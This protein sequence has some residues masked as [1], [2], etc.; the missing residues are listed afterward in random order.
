[1]NRF[2]SSDD[3]ERLI[4]TVRNQPALWHKTSLEY[5]I[6]KSEKDLVW[7]SVATKCKSDGN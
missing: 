1:M 6:K 4:E 2:V 5:R 3:V 7:T